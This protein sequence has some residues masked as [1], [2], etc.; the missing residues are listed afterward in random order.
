MNV[1]LEVVSEWLLELESNLSQLSAENGVKR[2][3]KTQS[4]S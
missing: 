2:G 1:Q 3:A 4:Q